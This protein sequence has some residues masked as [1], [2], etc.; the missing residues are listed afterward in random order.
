MSERRRDVRP[1]DVA[2]GLGL[3]AALLAVAAVGASASRDT[4]VA[5]MPASPGLVAV[6]VTP[7]VIGAPAGA[8]SSGLAAA[9][10]AAAQA[11]PDD[12]AAAPTSAVRPRKRRASQRA[13]TKPGGAATPEPAAD[14]SSPDDA[15]VP[16]GESASGDEAP[17]E[18]LG[19]EGTGGGGDSL[20]A[21]ALA[22]YRERLIRWF[23]ARFHVR[24]SGLGDALLS[25]RARAEVEISEGGV[26]LGYRVLS[27][28]HPALEGAAREAL[29]AVL[30]EPLPPPPDFFPGAPQRRLRITFVCT[31]S[32]CD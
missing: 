4:L 24:G 5:A 17:G 20:Q 7:V 8:S 26:V 32:T 1:G 28:D 6:Q 15:A 23:S 22:A 21:R 14:A 2:L 11:Q 19:G 10:A 25:L 29:D 12:V 27:A 31:E 30:G 13:S 18:E 9:A 3:A 16:A